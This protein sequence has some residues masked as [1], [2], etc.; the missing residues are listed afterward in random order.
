MPRLLLL[1]I[2]IPLSACSLDYGIEEDTETL[3]IPEYSFSSALFTQYE[4]GKRSMSMLASQ[5]EQYR[6]DTV[7]YAKEVQFQVYNDENNISAEGKSGL[8]SADSQNELYVLSR[9]IEIMSY[10]DNTRVTGEWLKWDG[11]SEQLIST[12]EDN[13]TIVQ[14]E[15][16]SAVEDTEEN[17]Q[18]KSRVSV[19]GRG[20]SA[21]G[22]SRSYAFTSD[23]SGTIETDETDSPS[24]EEDNTP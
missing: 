5:L 13:I 15:R 12:I 18:N 9:D 3:S 10:E 17:R 20:F 8:L 14:G 23:V 2:L 22:V 7:I 24:S 11:N 21:S 19:K 4:D 6:D 1:C 16:E